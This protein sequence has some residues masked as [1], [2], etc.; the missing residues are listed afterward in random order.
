VWQVNPEISC[1]LQKVSQHESEYDYFNL[2]NLIRFTPGEGYL[3]SLLEPNVTVVT[4]EIDK[5][6]ETGIDLTNGR[7]FDLDAII[8]ATGFDCSHRPPFS[9]IGRN[10]RKLS[11][12]WKDEPLHYMSVA[13]PGFPNYFSESSVLL[14]L[15]ISIFA[16]GVIFCSYWRSKQSNCKRITHIRS[17]D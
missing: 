16:N 11:E 17:G 10:G 8:C 5:I 3:E 14:S 7:H 15:M 2:V 6:T 4:C 1:R 9:V 12:Y 13:A